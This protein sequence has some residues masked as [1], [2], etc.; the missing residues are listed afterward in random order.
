MINTTC[1]TTV[2]FTPRC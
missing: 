2:L 1:S